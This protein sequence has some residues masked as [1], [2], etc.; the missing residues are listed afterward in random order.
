MCFVRLPHGRRV[1]YSE[2][3]LS[4][5]VNARAR[6]FVFCVSVCESMCSCVHVSLCVTRKCGEGSRQIIPG[7]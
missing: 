3:S 7:M 1:I 5:G 6:V 2:P 4:A